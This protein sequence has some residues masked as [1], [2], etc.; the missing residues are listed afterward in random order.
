MAFCFGIKDAHGTNLERRIDQ[1]LSMGKSATEMYAQKD[2]TGR[3]D[4]HRSKYTEDQIKYVQECLS[5]WAYYYG[6]ADVQE[7][8]TGFFFKGEQHKEECLAKFNQFK[9]D[10]I[11]AIER[12]SSETYEPTVYWHNHGPNR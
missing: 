3:L 5:E 1:V 9:I 12:V 6:Y 4:V 7:N 8:P 11:A 10:N 2:T